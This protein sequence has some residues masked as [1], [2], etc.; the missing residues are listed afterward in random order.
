[1]NVIFLGKFFPNNLLLSVL[2][3]SYKKIGFS[4]HNFEMSIINGL[5][6]QPGIELRCI[7]IPGVFSF[8]H[9][10]KK[11]FTRAQEYDYM[12]TKIYST[13]FCN[14]VGIKEK[15]ATTNCVKIFNKV[16]KTLPQGDVH[17]IINTPD[18]RLLDV[19][20][21][22]KKSNNRRITQTVIIPDIP[23][24]VTSM[25]KQF[26]LKKI[27]LNHRDKEAIKRTEESDGIVVLTNEMMDFFKKPIKHIVM[28]GIVDVQSMD[29]SN[30]ETNN[31]KEI[32]LYTGTLRKIF[33]V[34]NL[35]SAFKK[36]PNKDVELWICGSG[37]SKE[38][39]EAAAIADSRIKFFGL[40]SSKTA[41]E[42]QHKATILVNP[43]T[44]EGEYT[45]YSF[46]S[47]TME[48]LLAAKSV[49]INRLPGIPEE[50]YNFVYTPDNE[51]VE[52][53][54]KCLQYVLNSDR[55][56]RTKRAEAGRQFIVKQKNSKVQIER[57]IE[58]IKTY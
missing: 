21:L 19:I 13:G 32:I 15:H 17:V 39:I 4:N 7:S 31:A 52:S 23:S 38:A 8:P 11:L 37:D 26:V 34:M 5:C 51:S 46:P 12:N 53:F 41:L 18:I 45:K 10:N 28:E 55:E 49:V 36:I 35:I 56:M 16:L 44:S 29:I 25:D 42:M 48:Y 40:V 6:Q 14:M 57:I 2:D 27:I 50:Y 58:L 47:K 24:M 30:Q 54:A 3:D 9:N 33:G 1:M 22:I 43:R 20:S